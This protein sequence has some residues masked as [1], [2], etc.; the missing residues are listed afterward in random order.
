MSEEAYTTLSDSEV[1]KVIHTRVAVG[2]V[3][4]T[5][6]G[7]RVV[8]LYHAMDGTLLAYF[9]PYLGP[10]DKAI[11]SGMLRMCRLTVRK[12]LDEMDVAYDRNVGGSDGEPA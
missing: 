6:D 4:V 5:G 1:I 3:P 12:E 11:Q 9:D 7:P 10:I 8:H 2:E